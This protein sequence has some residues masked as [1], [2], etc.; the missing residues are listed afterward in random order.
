MLTS[1]HTSPAKTFPAGAIMLLWTLPRPP[2]G[3]TKAAKAAAVEAA[4]A[5]F[6]TMFKET[7]QRLPWG[8]PG[9]AINTIE[10]CIPFLKRWIAAGRA[11]IGTALQEGD[12]NERERIA[13]GGSIGEVWKMLREGMGNDDPGFAEC[14]AVASAAL[15]LAAGD[16]SHHV[17]KE[18]V[19]TLTKATAGRLIG[20][21]GASAAGL[22]L[23]ASCLS[24]LTDQL[25]VARCLIRHLTND[26][27]PP[28]V[29]AA[30]AVGLGFL[31]RSPT[32]GQ[33]ALRRSLLTEIG[34]ALLSTVHRLLPAL[35]LPAGDPFLTGPDRSMKTPSFGDPGPNDR[36]LAEAGLIG[37][38][39]AA[40]AL[41]T[42]GAGPVLATLAEALH[43][44]LRT[45]LQERCRAGHNEAGPR[46]AK[47][48]LPA[49]AAAALP[50]I[51]LALLHSN[52]VDSKVLVS[53]LDTLTEIGKE[54]KDDGGDLQML[55]AALP[56][57]GQILAR[58]WTADRLPDTMAMPALESATAALVAHTALPYEASAPVRAAAAWG[59]AWLLGGGST[60][61]V[62]SERAVRCMLLGVEGCA[63]LAKAALKALE[64]GK[65]DPDLRCRQ[66][67]MWALATASYRGSRAGSGEGVTS[68]LSLSRLDPDGALRPLI[69]Y[70]LEV[71]GKLVSAAGTDVPAGQL[72]AVLRCVAAAPRL[73]EIGWSP[74]LNRISSAFVRDDKGYDRESRPPDGRAVPCGCLDVA[75]RH[76]RTGSHGLVEFLEKRLQIST[77]SVLHLAEQVFLLA[78]MDLILEA[79]PAADGEALC[80]R[81]GR[82]LDEATRNFDDNAPPHTEEEGVSDRILASSPSSACTSGR[83][84]NPVIAAWR[85]MKAAMSRRPQRLVSKAVEQL[86]QRLPEPESFGGE[87][88]EAPEA[89]WEEALECLSKL[90]QEEV[91]EQLRQLGDQGGKAVANAAVMRARLIISEVLPISELVLSK[92]A[93]VGNGGGGVAVLA[94]NI[95]RATL[96]M[97]IAEQRRQLLD[98]FDA[99]SVCG[100]PMRGLE[101]AATIAA[102]L[103]SQRSSPIMVSITACT[104]SQ[105]VSCLSYTLPS[106]LE[107]PA[108]QST[109][110]QIVSRLRELFMLEIESAKDLA[111]EVRELLSTVG[112]NCVVGLR[113]L[114]PPASLGIVADVLTSA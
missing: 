101:L 79:L 54:N 91:V 67:A 53:W 86:L 81:L 36:D 45:A 32:G 78:N 13:E 92:L 63:P 51:G 31:S 16:K 12:A 108:W 70:L 93:Y 34:T 82:L 26:R 106:L 15:P 80:G 65:N 41:V 52:A 29:S 68:G 95:A 110:T 62:Q 28:L 21:A 112:A 17:T 30:A 100:D 113:F 114:L 57:L 61:A 83:G 42:C 56:A 22:G 74:L 76:A 7:A 6:A 38:G 8:G 50:E 46:V 40:P 98:S 1:L 85:G 64:E 99:I 19:D 59:L 58:A 89:V 88:R 87:H 25:A 37:L 66:Q 96:R 43:Q 48:Y 18:V 97:G 73:P 69:E 55:E 94:R 44:S 75:V 104:P 14:C 102:Y 47:D 84:V 20:V 109:I 60:G 77:F 4:P 11:S 90:P 35:H 33:E 103:E 39:L 23:A 2:E 9:Q 49:L 72:A 71:D 27:G 111:P 107:Q 3:A 10:A 5:A 105:A 24:S